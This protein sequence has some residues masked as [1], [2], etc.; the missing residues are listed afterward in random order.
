MTVPS[1]DL[2]AALRALGLR[3]PGDAL[4]ALLVHATRSRLSPTQTLEQLVAL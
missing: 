3:A 2:P 1:A 4:S